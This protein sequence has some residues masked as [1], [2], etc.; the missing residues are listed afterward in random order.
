MENFKFDVEGV[1]K[2]KE[3]LIEFYED[4]RLK[5]K[6]LPIKIHNK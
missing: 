5:H 1:L 3:T 4:E 6:Q 2:I